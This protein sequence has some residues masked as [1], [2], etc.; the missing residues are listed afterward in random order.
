MTRS[1][2]GVVGEDFRPLAPTSFLWFTLP[3]AAASVD[4]EVALAR[5]DDEFPMVGTVWGIA[6]GLLL[7]EGWLDL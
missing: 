1:F 4:L 6:I 7:T 2:L 5:E 3:P